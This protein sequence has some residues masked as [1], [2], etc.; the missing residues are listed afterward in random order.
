MP[1]AQPVTHTEDLYH[2]AGTA[3]GDAVEQAATAVAGGDFARAATAAQRL[4]RYAGHV[5]VAVVRDALAAGADWWQ[6]GEHLGLHPQAAYE[7]Y[8]G[9]S[10]GLHPPAQQ[11]PQLAVVC[12]AGL[13]AHHDQADEYGVDLDDLGDDHSLTQDPTVLRLRLAAAALGE[14]VWIAVRLPGGYEG[15]DDLDDGAASAR[16]MTVV[17][18]PDDLGWLREA[19]QLR[20]ENPAEDED[21]LEAL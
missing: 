17:T 8:R 14:D 11:H 3:L 1:K 16:W 12:T 6:L 2:R 9:A 10:E 20:T 7:Q 18:R 5:Q 4:A 19:L 21:D 13:L 15:A